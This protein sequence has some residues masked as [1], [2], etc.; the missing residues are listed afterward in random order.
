M[1]NAPINLII[2]IG[3]HAVAIDPATG[4]ELWRTRLKSSHFVTVKEEPSCVYAGAGGELF[5][6]DRATGEILWRN[7]LKGLG[8][9]VIGFSGD[10]DVVL[11]AAAAAARTAAAATAAS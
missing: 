11:A 4:K 9:G 7:R 2:G 6:L 1:S 5:C 10:S 3:G 8:L